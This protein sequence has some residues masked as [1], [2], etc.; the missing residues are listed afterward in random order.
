MEKL[1]RQIARESLINEMIQDGKKH[2]TM[3]N[4]KSCLNIVFECALDDDIILKNPAKNL[5][6]PQTEKRERT[7]IDRRQIDLFMNYVKNSERYAYSYPAFVVLFNLGMRI[8][9][10]AAL[11]WGD[12][13]F[14]ENIISINKT[15]NRYR[16]KDYG[17][18]VAVAS[19]KSKTSIRNVV[20]NT[21]VRTTLLKLKMQNTAHV[22]GLPFVD[23]S[24][25]IRGTISDFLFVNTYG[26]VWNEPGFR[27]LIK[28]IVEQYNREAEEKHTEKIEDFCP[29]MVRHTYTTLAYSAGADVKI[30]SQN[31]GHASTSVTLDVYTHLTEE[32]KKEQESVAQVIKIS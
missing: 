27:E 21:V 4:L 25:N 2:S 15:V 7:A 29:H 16:K 6:I 14:K 12:V 19:P 30:V 17:Y 28:R 3:A 26:N 18:T 5:Q 24:G 11:T 1:Q 8:G 32:K 13:N 10:M 9:E 31:L 20:M 22:A 23:D